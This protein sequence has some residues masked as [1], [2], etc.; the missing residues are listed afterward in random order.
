[1]NCF[2]GRILGQEEQMDVSTVSIPFLVILSTT[3]M[4][5]EVVFPK[6]VQEERG[7]ITQRKG[8]LLNIRSK[9]ENKM[10][11]NEVEWQWC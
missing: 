11:E 7:N 4:T 1:M 6:P 2:H 10:R 8:Q 9:E 5:S 3:G